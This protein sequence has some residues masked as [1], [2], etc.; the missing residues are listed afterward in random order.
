MHTRLLLLLPLW[1]K[2]PLAPEALHFWKATAVWAAQPVFL[3]TPR[4]ET[5]SHP[6]SLPRQG[7]Q[8]GQTAGIFQTGGGRDLI[9]R[10]TQFRGQSVKTSQAAWSPCHLL[11]RQLWVSDVS[12][13]FL[14]C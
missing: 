11:S 8:E 10:G 6:V 4:G 12:S 2:G 3:L 13:Q 9:L 5:L 7:P 1:V 14:I